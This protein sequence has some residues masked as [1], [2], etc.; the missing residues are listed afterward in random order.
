MTTKKDAVAVV[1]PGTLAA[2]PDFLNP[3]DKRGVEHLRREDLQLP[4]LVLA[5]KMS[6]EV[7]EAAPEY[8]D[9][10]KVGQLFNNM[11]KEIYAP[12][13]EF[14]VVRADPPRWVEFYPRTEG[15]GVKDLH[16]PAQH[17]GIPGK[18]DPR[19]LFLDGKPPIAT[20]FYDFVVMLLPTREIVAVSF[21][22]TQIPMAKHLN[23]LMFD[24]KAPSFAG[25]YTVT[26]KPDQNKKGSFMSFVIDDARDESNRRAWVTEDVFR[27]AEAIYTDIKD[28]VLAVDDTPDVDPDGPD[29]E[30]QPEM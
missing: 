13:L 2:R 24:R 29:A 28:K 11:T 19:T 12:V 18:G 26:S 1:S 10:L 3:A 6:P 23:S 25:R 17:A 30:K 15:G 5:Q 7:D 4:R 16:V 27:E 20:Q 8:M 9:G 14:T 21:K 22:S